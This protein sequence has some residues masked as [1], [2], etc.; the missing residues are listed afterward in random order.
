[1]DVIADLPADA[2]TTEPVQQGEDLF[3]DL[4]MGAQLKPC[5]VPRHGMTGSMALSRRR[6]QQAM[7]DPNSGSSL[8]GLE[9][10]ELHTKR[11]TDTKAYSGHIFPIHGFMWGKMLARQPPALLA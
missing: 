5:G 4:A 9:R 6:H 7:L 1:M 11:E 10:N 3:H 8:E 2:Q